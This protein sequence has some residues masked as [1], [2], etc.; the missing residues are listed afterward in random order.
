MSISLAPRGVVGP[1]AGMDVPWLLR[2]RAESRRDHPFLVWAPFDAPARRWTYGEFHERVGALA[3][4]LAGRGIKSG[5]FVLIHLDNCI[6]AVLAWFACV[7]LGAIA[8]TTNTRSAAA[9]MEYF[10]GHCGAVAAITQPAYAETISRHCRGLRWLAVT[11]HDAGCAPAIGSV[12]RENAF[13]ALFADSAD[14][15][16]RATDPHAPCSV[17]YTSGTTSRPKAVLWTH[18]NA[19]WGAKVNAAHQ[20]L[21]ASDVHQTYLPLFH[22]N[23]LAYSMLASLWVG[24]TCVIQP[25][26][27]AS[28]FWSVALEHGCTWTSTIPF[29][30]KALLE[31]E[32]PKRHQFRLWG[33]AVCEPPAFSVF[34][35]KIIGWWGMTETITHG[36]IGEVDQPNTPMSIGRAASEYSIR[37]T[38]DNGKPTEVGGTGNLSIQ[39]VPG[40]SLF[41]EYLHN[42]KA[43][44]ESF[45]E[46]GYFITGDR[47]T[48]LEHGYIKF[49]DRAKDMLKVGGENVAASEI[50]QVIAVVPGVREAAVVAKKHPM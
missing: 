31:H 38:D 29:C 9:E 40:L 45:D 18:A 4:G 36:I 15:P 44:S 26:F 46:H 8:V 19:L 41:A 12:P 7:E 28:R 30:M 39:G 3:A 35:I 21:H 37:I 24:A 22:T 42:E 48:L 17:Q 25:R 32:I 43:T 47:V 20:E 50:E 2:M 6:E 49:G 10:A 13:E 14:R 34:G 1:F 5:E 23:A 27:S 11:S 16:R 33:T